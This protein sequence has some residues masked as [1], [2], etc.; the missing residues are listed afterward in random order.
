M[1]KIRNET[2]K[3]V[4]SFLQNS[5][6]KNLEDAEIILSYLELT[7]EIVLKYQTEYNKI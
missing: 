3:T 4:Y 2:A 7:K 6:V 5:T 1:L